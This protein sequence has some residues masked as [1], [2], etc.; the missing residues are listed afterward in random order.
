MILT[1]DKK[2]KL[3]NYFINR[4]SMYEYRRGWLKGDCPSCGEHKFG[5]NI[6]QNRSNCFKCGYN[7]KPID[8]LM[9]IESIDNY[10]D[11]RLFLDNLNSVDFIEFKDVSENVTRTSLSQI[12]NNLPDY[13]LPIDKGN[14][15]IARV[16]RSYLKRRGFNIENL[17]K[18][19]WGYCYKGKYMGYIIIPFY[20]NFRLIYFNARLFITSGPKFNNPPVEEFGIGKSHIIYNSDALDIYDKIYI[21][22]SVTNAIT[23][24][25]NAIAICGKVLS[26]YQLNLIIKSHCRKVIVILDRD[27][28]YWAIKIAFELIDFKKVKLVIPRDNRDVNDLGRTNTFKLIHKFKY[29]NYNELL[30]L[31]NKYIQYDKAS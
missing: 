28:T 26:T 8:V 6:S 17:K 3:Y 1:K 25:D 11:L 22:E 2:G 9:F 19:G 16:A 18:A 12:N 4:M 7:D 14:N 20:S 21:V 15:R 29:L 27:A 10:N 23:I 13:F 5:L 24:G 31:K 30:K